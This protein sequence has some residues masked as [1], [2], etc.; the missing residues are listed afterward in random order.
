MDAPAY[1]R[2]IAD[3]GFESYQLFYWK[4]ALEIDFAR[5]AGE[6]SE[7]LADRDAV[8]SSLGVYGNPLEFDVDAEVARRSW[9]LCIDHAGDFGCGLVCGFAGRL[10]GKPIHESMERRPWV[11]GAWCNGG[12]S[13]KAWPAGHSYRQ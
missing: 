4:T 9:E 5:L 1:V 7:V 8:I 10:R 3:H 11:V 12:F 6:M 2:Q 13:G